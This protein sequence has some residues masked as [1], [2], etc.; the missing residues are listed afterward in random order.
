MSV[1]AGRGH[2]SQIASLNFADAS[3][4]RSAPSATRQRSTSL[5]GRASPR[6]CEPKRYRRLAAAVRDSSLRGSAPVSR[7][8][9]RGSR[10]D[11]RAAISRW[12]S[13]GVGESEASW[14]IRV[15]PT[16]GDNLATGRRRCGGVNVTQPVPAAGRSHSRDG[17][18]HLL[19]G[20]P[21][22]RSIRSIH[23]HDIGGAFWSARDL[24][25][26]S[27]RAERVPRH[28]LHSNPKAATSSRTP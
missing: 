17:L 16:Y 1:K 26:L 3:S 4:C 6:A 14:R 12:Q 23:G 27:I 28:L 5:S 2:T 15:M 19:A 9:A 7:A 18:C 13:S 20:H 21:S 25:P 24:S 8:A 22:L 11:Y 10:E